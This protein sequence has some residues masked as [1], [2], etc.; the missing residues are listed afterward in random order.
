MSARRGGC[1][2]GRETYVVG[3]AAVEPEMGGYFNGEGPGGK[4]GGVCGH[5]DK[6]R[7]ESDGGDSVQRGQVEARRLQD[8]RV[9]TLV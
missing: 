8:E 7:I 6:S 1:E 2:D 5:R 3:L 4:Y 9:S